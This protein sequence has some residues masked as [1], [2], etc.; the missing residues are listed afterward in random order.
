MESSCEVPTAISDEAIKC[1][2]GIV[3]GFDDFMREE[4]G[5]VVDQ[6]VA[7]RKSTVIAAQM[8]QLTI[9]ISHEK[10]TATEKAKDV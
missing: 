9:N 6:P 2:I 4:F 1:A 5:V 10:R 3:Q 8:I 7:A